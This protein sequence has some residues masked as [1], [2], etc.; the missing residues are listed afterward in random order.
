M[1]DTSRLGPPLY[2]DVGAIA[3]AI[4][5][6]AP[7]RVVWASNWPHP[8]QFPKP[9]DAMLLDTLLDYA[10]DDAT[11]AAILVANP[12]RLYRFD[13]DREGPPP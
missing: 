3:R 12:A 8:G 6:H 9:D 4:I 5:A 1:Y 13:R 11:R 10:P 7:Q 2:P